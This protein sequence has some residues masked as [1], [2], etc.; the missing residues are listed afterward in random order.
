MEN[1]KKWYVNE[2]LG[3]YEGHFFVVTLMRYGHRCGYVKVENHELFERIKKWYCDF[4]NSEFSFNVHGGITFCE[5]DPDN[6][7]LSKGDWIGFDCNHAGDL[8]DATALFN[9]FNDISD[10]EFTLIV[11]RV[12][13]GRG[14]KIRSTDYVSGEC[15]KLIDQL[16]KLGD[17]EDGE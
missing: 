2:L 12:L 17:V 4:D 15:R 11:D 8:I 10:G 13:M 9:E 16:I 6:H 7:H 1:E 3:G 5:S 14:G